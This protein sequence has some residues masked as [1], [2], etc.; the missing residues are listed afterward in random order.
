MRLCVSMCFMNFKLW[1]DFLLCVE[2]KEAKKELSPYLFWIPRGDTTF[3]SVKS[4]FLA[5]ISFKICFFIHNMQQLSIR[6]FLLFFMFWV[7][8]KILWG[9]FSFVYARSIRLIIMFYGKFQKT[10]AR[11][12]WKR[13]ST[14]VFKKINFIFVKN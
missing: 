1:K 14:R 8:F 11:S 4:P 3:Y 2:T 13:G 7:W 5:R 10:C 12:F 9:S 6:L